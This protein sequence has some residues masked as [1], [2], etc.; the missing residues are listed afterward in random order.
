MATITG[1]KQL[2][3]KLKRLGRRGGKKAAAAG[4]RASLTPVR[5]AMRAAINAS[6]ASKELKRAARKT[7]ASRFKKSRKTGRKEAKVGLGVGKQKKPNKRSGTAGVGI[8]KTNIHWF[9]LGTDERKTKSGRN[10]GRIEG[11]FGDVT[12]TAFAR[13]QSDAIAAARKKID[14]VIQQEAR[15]A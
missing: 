4:V 14:Q 8:S 1:D 9:V 6:G 2:D 5:K 15:K 3:R 7:V 10:A 12:D 13:S 11:V